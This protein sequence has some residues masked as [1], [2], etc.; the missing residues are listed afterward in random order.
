MTT[1]W[2]HNKHVPLWCILLLTI[3]VFSPTFNN[4]FQMGWDD[5]WMVTNY[6]T[7]DGLALE[8]IFD[9]FT[10]IYGGQYAPINQL[11]Y[12]CIYSCF[13]YKPFWYHTI[14]LVFHLFNVVLVYKIMANLYRWDKFKINEPSRKKVALFCSL[15]F[16]INPLQVESVAWVSASK[17]VLFAFFYLAG[18]LVYIQFIEKGK[19]RYIITAIFLFIMSLG[20]KEQAVTFPAWLIMLHWIHGDFKDKSKSLWGCVPFIIIG[21]AF[22]L[23]YLLYASCLDGDIKNIS[24]GY[25]LFER[26]NIAG[27]AISVYVRRWLLPIDLMHIYQLP[28]P[29]PF[30]FILCPFCF[31][32]LFFTLRKKINDTIL[33]WLLFYVI[34]LALV[35]H[36]IPMGRFV[37]TADRYM[38]LPCISLANLF[39]LLYISI[40]KTKKH[41]WGIICISSLAL[42]W[43]FISFDRCLDWKNTETIRANN[44]IF[45]NF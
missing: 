13:Y 7:S 9:I 15:C 25:S 44:T 41:V 36:I 11:L 28:N 10:N 20:C 34:H 14:S 12:S 33:F 26:F 31:I 32:I 43:C 4:G 18:T 16:A 37:I 17:V 42:F 39:W 45:N 35:L 3:A 22:G 19:I 40:M 27:Y 5:Q 6:Y 1:N 30:W 21:V 2:I 23:F 38:Y 24:N 29:I 8:N